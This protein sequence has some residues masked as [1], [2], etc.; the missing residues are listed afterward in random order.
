MSKDAA[1]MHHCSFCQI[2]MRFLPLKWFGAAPVALLS[3]LHCRQKPQQHNGRP[4]FRHSPNGR[5]EEWIT[6]IVLP[7]LSLQPALPS[8]CFCRMAALR[9]QQGRWMQINLKAFVAGGEAASQRET[10]VAGVRLNLYLFCSSGWHW[11]FFL[12]VKLCFADL[13]NYR[14]LCAIKWYTW[15]KRRIQW[16]K[17]CK[18]PNSLTVKGCSL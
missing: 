3:S 18:R 4:Y 16:I 8:P 13:T 6:R 11:N 2:W 15:C 9:R 12:P 7:Y 17:K 5:W 1:S 14:H 10:N